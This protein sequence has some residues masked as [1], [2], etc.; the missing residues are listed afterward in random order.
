MSTPEE[1]I[2]EEVR[3][4]LKAGQRE[5]TATLRMLLNEIKNEK[6]RQQEEVDE[7]GFLRLVRRAIKQREDSASQYEEGGR[8]ELAAKER[9]EIGILEAY[10]PEELDDDTLRQAIAEIID[11]DE[12]SGPGD[13]GPLMKQMMARFAGQADGGRINRLVREALSD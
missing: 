2:S 5:R 7:T 10:L 3:T 8:Q 12:L 4:A 6:I 11:Q 13:L 9:G 1:R